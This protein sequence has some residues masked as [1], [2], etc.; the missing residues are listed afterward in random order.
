MSLAEKRA[1]EARGPLKMLNGW[2][3]FLGVH[4]PVREG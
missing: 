2:P 4:V 1:R 3:T